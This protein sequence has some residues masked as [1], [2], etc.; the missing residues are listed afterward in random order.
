MA[1]HIAPCKIIVMVRDAIM[2]LTGIMVLLM[3]T[4]GGIKYVYSADDA[5][6][7]KAAKKICE[8][9]IIGGILAGLMNEVLTVLGNTPYCPT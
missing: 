1:I 6:G 3:F 5:G 7:R 4:Y 2:S 8:H 9:A